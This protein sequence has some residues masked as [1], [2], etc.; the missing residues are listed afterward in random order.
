LGGSPWR[1]GSGH[2]LLVHSMCRLPGA[3]G[4]WM[5]VRGGMGTVTRTIAAR[6]VEAGATIRTGVAAERIAVAGGRASGVVTEGGEEIG[7]S[8]VLVATDPYRLPALL[9]GACP[10]ELRARIDGYVG[11]TLGQT[12]KVNL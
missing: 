6:A 2:N 11:G 4:T 5:A 3:G 10:A 12:M 8:A 7:A 9:A 1:P